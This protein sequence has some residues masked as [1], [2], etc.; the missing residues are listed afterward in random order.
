MLALKRLWAQDGHGRAMPSSLESPSCLPA[1]GDADPDFPPAR[2]TAPPEVSAQPV[3]ASGDLSAAENV[4]RPAHFQRAADGVPKPRARPELSTALDAVMKATDLIKEAEARADLKAQRATD[5]AFRTFAQLERMEAEAE[6]A[7]RLVRDLRGDIADA[8]RRVTDA[9]RAS[10]TQLVAAQRRIAMLE[11]QVA[12]L[13]DLLD[14]SKSLIQDAE[15]RVFAAETRA[16]EARED[17]TFLEGHIRQQFAI[18]QAGA[19]R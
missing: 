12:D 16:Q 5:V 10:E 3:L 9:V 13:T 4:V 17:V 8:D 14:E 15:T 11:A 1:D 18:G 2:R 6:A 7:H 19:A